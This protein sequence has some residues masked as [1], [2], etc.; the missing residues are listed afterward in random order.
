MTKSESRGFES[1]SRVISIK[2]NLLSLIVYMIV[3]VYTR[4]M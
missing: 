1:W 2:R 4:P 3:P